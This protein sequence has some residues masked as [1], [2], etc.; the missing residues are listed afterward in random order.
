MPKKLN[1]RAAL[2]QA[3]FWVEHPLVQGLISPAASR[4]VDP[5]SGVFSV[6][7]ADGF[8][9]RRGA[10][11]VITAAGC[12][13]RSSPLDVRRDDAGKAPSCL[14]PDKR[15][16]SVHLVPKRRLVTKY[17]HRLTLNFRQ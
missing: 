9:H 13:G 7:V 15:I 1:N 11:V 8:T 6:M 2:V 14:L 12:E 5:I 4:F 16:W 3:T 17:Q 10:V